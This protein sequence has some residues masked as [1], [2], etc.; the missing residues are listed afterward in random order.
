MIPVSLI[1]QGI[2]SYKE[3][4]TIEFGQLLNAHLFGI[5]GAVGSGKS[6]ILEA[7]SFALYGQTERLSKRDDQKYNMMNLASSELF[8]EFIFRAGI[9]HEH[10]YKFTVIGKRNSRRFEDVKKFDRKAYCKD[11]LGWMPF[12]IDTAES[13]LGISYENFKRTIII[14]QGMFQEFIQLEPSKRTMMMMELFNLQ[15]YDL[16]ENVSILE[17]KNFENINQIKGR[18]SQISD[19]STPEQLLMMEA[20][21]AI[22]SPQLTEKIREQNSLTEINNA[23]T[24]LQNLTLLYQEIEKKLVEI[25]TQKEFFI[26]KEE[27]IKQYEICLQNFKDILTQYHKQKQTLI[28]M[29][30]SLEQLIKDD[31]FRQNEHEVLKEKWIIIKA[32]YELRDQNREKIDDLERLISI[33]DIELKLISGHHEFDQIKDALHKMDTAFIGVKTSIEFIE[34]EVQELKKIQLDTQ[35]LIQIQKWFTENNYLK[36]NLKTIH[37]EIIQ[38]EKQQHELEVKKD[39][40]LALPEID[41]FLTTEERKLKIN[42]ITTILNSKISELSNFISE[43]DAKLEELS[44]SEKLFDY[45]QQVQTGKPCP[46]C[47]ASEHPQILKLEDVS[48]AKQ[49]IG[50]EKRKALTTIERLTSGIGNLNKLYGFF[51]TQFDNNKIKKEQVNQLELKIK[52]HIQAFI[53][54]EYSI[55][56]EQKINVDFAAATQQKQDIINKE[57]TLQQLRIQLETDREFVENKRQQFEL[58]STSNSQL[59]MQ[60][61]TLIKQMK[62]INIEAYEDVLCSR[63][64]QEKNELINLIQTTDMSYQLISQQIID[65]STQL[66]QITGQRVEKEKQLE[67]FQKEYEQIHEKIVN[68]MLVYQYTQMKDIS[69]VLEKNI[70]CTLENQKV[71]AYNANRQTQ[72][73]EKR[74][75][76]K[77]LNGKIYNSDVHQQLKQQLETMIRHVGALTKEKI[78]LESKIIQLKSDFDKQAKLLKELNQLELRATNLATLKSLFIG[79]KFVDYISTQYLQNLTIAANERFAKLTRQQLKLEVNNSNDFIVRDVLNEGKPRSIKTLSGG[80]TFQAALSLALSLADQVNKMAGLNQNFFFM[81]EG[82]GSLDKESL[83]TVFESLKLLHKEN[84]IV[85]I[86][87]H[88]EDMQLD[89]DVYLKIIKDDKRGS[90]VQ[91]S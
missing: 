38:N 50:N 74:T 63:I 17:N 81:D 71:S 84:R 8:I 90:L 24:S 26:Q 35:L 33:K 12:D 51:K 28:T 87:S 14:P 91:R 58:I 10:E 76:E 70:D 3:R 30:D 59:L 43:M 34:K 55:H 44:G 82:F 31:L 61:V 86:I 42:D 25:E 80:Q 20:Q 22:I 1:L 2:Y 72:Q 23:Q 27:Q 19:E 46:L 37:N 40:L 83:R 18:I 47:G 39:Q 7:I 69:D 53:W 54:T 52:M 11:K 85:G 78:E 49:K 89:M 15:K 75:L 13:V 21:L 64:K 79:K 41:Q 5:F 48:G 67:Q 62:Q 36:E 66:S 6:T 77:Q 16:S 32:S 45:V 4:Q 29:T 60:K 56:E 9:Q 73:V 88:V 57:N 68:R 65:V